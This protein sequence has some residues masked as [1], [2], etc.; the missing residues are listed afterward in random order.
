VLL[1]FLLALG[2]VPQTDWQLDIHRPAEWCSM[3]TPATIYYVYRGCGYPSSE[4]P[5]PSI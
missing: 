2:F 5:Y 3:E 1:K 4:H